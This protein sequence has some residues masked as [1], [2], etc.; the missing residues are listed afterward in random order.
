MSSSRDAILRA[1]RKNRPAASPLPDPLRANEFDAREVQLRFASVIKQIG[2]RLVDAERAGS[3]ERAVQSCYPNAERIASAVPEQ[4]AG[5]RELRSVTDPHELADVDL[6]VCEAELGVAEN[7][8]VWVSES[9]IVHRAAPI[10]AEHLAVV[11]DR[12]SIVPDMHRAYER[13]RVREDGYGVFIAGPSKTADIEQS[14][15]IGA[16]GPRS[17]TIMLV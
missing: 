5:N 1:I 12:S 16:H 2:A 14:L 4:V 8:A 11:L 10:I 15:V 6:F 13:L 3:V 7:G 9:R 17:L